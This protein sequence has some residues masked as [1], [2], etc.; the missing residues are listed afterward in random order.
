MSTFLHQPS[1]TT[2]TFVIVVVGSSHGLLLPIAS[3]YPIKRVQERVQRREKKR[4]AS[5]SNMCESEKYRF[6][7]NTECKSETLGF[8]IVLG[9][10]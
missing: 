7:R 1:T 3:I 4:S 8:G 5:E 9:L 2:M 6:E 10:S